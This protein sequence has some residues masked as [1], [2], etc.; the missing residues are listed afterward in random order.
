MNNP[1]KNPVTLT[2]IT[3]SDMGAPIGG[4]TSISLWMNG[5][6]IDTVNVSGSN[7]TFNINEVISGNN[8]A[9]TFEVTANFSSTATAGSYPF[10]VSN[11]A[12]NN[13]QALLF[14]GIPLTGATVSVAAPTATLTV[15]PTMT[16]TFTSMPT[17]TKTPT[18]SPKATVVVYPNPST[19]GTV[20]LNPNL[21]T[22]SNVSI[23]IF[24]IAFRR[25]ASINYSNV[26]PGESLPIPLVDKAGTPLASGL[27]YI[28]VQTDRGR[29]V[30]KL[31]LLH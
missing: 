4:V 23:E 7:T 13:G 25:V 16:G 1:S 30:V 18:P 29:S 2:N 5:A 27:Y 12:G 26:Q 31:L 24:T 15:T 6:V 8:G 14:T 11:A 19:G 22:E 3:V 20:Q 21:T 10:S 17:A 9:V 28:V